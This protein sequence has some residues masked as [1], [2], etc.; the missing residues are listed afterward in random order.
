MT[1]RYTF[2]D[3]LASIEIGKSDRVVA[4]VRTFILR[5]QHRQEVLYCAV[6]YDVNRRKQ[7]FS[8]EDVIKH[9]YVVMNPAGGVSKSRF[10]YTSNEVMEIAEVVRGLA[11]THDFAY[12]VHTS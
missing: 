1:T 6:S 8:F 10:S 4:D 2:A 12:L 7:N 11:E 5:V 9:A 3:A